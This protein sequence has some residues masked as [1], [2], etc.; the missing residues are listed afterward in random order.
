[1]TDVQVD[2]AMERGADGYVFKPVTIEELEKV[3]TRAFQ[4]HKNK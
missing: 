3:M 1:V 4:K 2:A